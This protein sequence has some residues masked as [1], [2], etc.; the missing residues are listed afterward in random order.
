MC[1][2][3]AI[4]ITSFQRQN[5][6]SVCTHIS[7]FLTIQHHSPSC[8]LAAITLPDNPLAGLHGVLLPGGLHADGLVPG[9]LLGLTR[10]AGVL[11]RVAGLLLVVCPVPGELQQGEG[12]GSQPHRRLPALASLRARDHR[13]RVDIVRQ[14][15][16]GEKN[17]RVGSGGD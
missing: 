8:T 1:V 16:T 3:Q 5:S 17:Q 13:L 4:I 11:S 14:L 10:V 6:L 2:D 12:P 9:L 15:C 7:P